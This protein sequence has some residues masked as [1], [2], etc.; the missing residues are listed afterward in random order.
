MVAFSPHLLHWTLMAVI[1]KAPFI[2]PDPCNKD[3][4]QHHAS[5]TPIRSFIINVDCYHFDEDGIILAASTI[6]MV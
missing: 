5:P 4:A 6:V 1:R 3:K 2:E